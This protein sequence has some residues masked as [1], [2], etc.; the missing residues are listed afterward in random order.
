MRGYEASELLSFAR[1]IS[2]TYLTSLI[3][4]PRCSPTSVVNCRLSLF[5]SRMLTNTDYVISF[6]D[7]ATTTA[8]TSKP[9]QG[10]VPSRFQRL[11][12]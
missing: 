8:D 10:Q 3:T 4:F 2:I 12:I 6:G 1:Q 11:R 9:C 7:S 5:R